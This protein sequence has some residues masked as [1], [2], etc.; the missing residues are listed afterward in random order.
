MSVWPYSPG[1]PS[2]YLADRV[3]KLLAPRALRRFPSTAI[4]SSFFGCT[5]TA[6]FA[7]FWS[8]SVVSLMCALPGSGI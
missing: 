7:A 1:Y 4:L 5:L 8:L 3:R 6:E 2:L